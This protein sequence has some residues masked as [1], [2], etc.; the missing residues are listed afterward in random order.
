[1]SL[2]GNENQ[3]PIR[4]GTSIGDITAGLFTTIGIQSALIKRNI[5]KKVVILIFQC[6]TV[7]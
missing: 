2:T 3:D 1:M 5:T 4:V 7:K 6:W